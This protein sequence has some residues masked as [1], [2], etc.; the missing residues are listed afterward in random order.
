MTG[1]K[2]AEET[3]HNF[4][5][6]DFFLPNP[7]VGNELLTPEKYETVRRKVS[8]RKSRKRFL[9]P[10]IAGRLSHY[11]MKLKTLLPAF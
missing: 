6:F 4:L 8:E 10:P 5:T 3:R 1:D 7:H 2:R 9:L 11:E